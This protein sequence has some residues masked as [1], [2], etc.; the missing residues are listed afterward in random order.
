MAAYTKPQFN[1]VWATSGE[2]IAPL[3]AKINQGWIVEIPPYEYMNWIQ[4]RQDQMLAHINQMGIPVWDSQT[5]YQANKSYVQGFTTG[6]IYRAVI[7]HTNR[8]PETDPGG[9]WVKAFDAPGLSLLKDAN[10]SDVPD[11]A[12]ARAN[13]G[14]TTTS[15]YDLRYLLK[16]QNLADIPNKSTARSNLGLGSAATA[17]IGT[18]AGTVAA[19]DDTRI[20]NSVQNSRQIV[21]GNGLTGGGALSTDRTISLGTPSTI[22]SLT[23]NTVSPVSHSHAIDVNSIISFDSSGVTT[24]NGLKII[25]G[26]ATANSGPSGS[27]IITFSTPFPSACIAVW[28]TAVS[29]TTGGAEY[30]QII[31]YDRTGARGVTYTNSSGTVIGPVTFQYAAI[32]F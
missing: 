19:G 27:K 10:L 32:G 22:S 15:E 11:K 25:T 5:E 14:I 8:N 9:A 18:V 4:N 30:V 26:S 29:S 6:T 1:S 21:A 17:G 13:L 28:I 20:V 24:S 3:D 23:S 12:L 31:S 7:T 2:K 16:S